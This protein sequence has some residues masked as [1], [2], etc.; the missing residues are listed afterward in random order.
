VKCADHSGWKLKVFIAGSLANSTEKEIWKNQRNAEIHDEEIPIPDGIMNL[1]AD[2]FRACNTEVLICSQD[3]TD[4]IASFA[5]KDGASILSHGTE[6]FRYE[7]MSCNVYCNA[8]I[9]WKGDMEFSL[10][11]S[12]WNTQEKSSRTLVADLATQNQ[13]YTV[14]VDVI[15]HRQYSRGS[16]TPLLKFVENPHITVRP[17]RKALYSRLGIQGIVK[18]EMPCWNGEFEEVE[19]VIEDVEADDCH[20]GLLDHPMEALITLF[21]NTDSLYNLALK[22]PERKFKDHI[23]SLCTVTFEL[24]AIATGLNLHFLL[25]T[26][27]QEIRSFYGIGRLNLSKQLILLGPCSSCNQSFSMHQKEIDWFRNKGIAVPKRCKSCR[28][29]SKI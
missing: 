6:F 7:G 29:A 19:W 5:Q 21:P 23:F 26:H 18:E 25:K 16:P 10:V 13:K 3:C 27:Q 2:S 12:I 17:L 20:D 14:M 22:V 8:E 28:D 15:L 4:T 24:C 11:P 9:N 1:L